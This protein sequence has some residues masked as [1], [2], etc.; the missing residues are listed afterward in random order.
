MPWQWDYEHYS[1]EN[2]DMLGF[3]YPEDYNSILQIMELEAAGQKRAQE[4]KTK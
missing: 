1:D 4:A 2:S 3:F